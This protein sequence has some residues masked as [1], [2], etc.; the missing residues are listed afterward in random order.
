MCPFH[1]RHRRLRMQSFRNGYN[2]THC[3]HLSP[4]NSTFQVN[5]MN[6]LVFEGGYK[7][8]LSV[9]LYGILCI[10]TLISWLWTLFLPEP[11]RII[12]GLSSPKKVTVR[13]GDTPEL[14]CNATGSPPP[15]VNWFRKHIQGVGPD[16]GKER[17][18]LEPIP[19]ILSEKKMWL[20]IAHY[21]VHG[22]K[23][24]IWVI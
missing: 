9:Y 15:T 17:E 13:E 21:G 6:A 20:P 23:F 16:P 2:V 24:S 19:Y 1:H 18:S 12:T 22:H 10:W 5:L 11:S 4:S 14:V 8:V 3:Y 7:S